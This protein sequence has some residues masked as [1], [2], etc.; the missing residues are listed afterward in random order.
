MSENQ[1][2]IDKSKLSL[3]K[4][5]MNIL[6]PEVDN[7]PPAGLLITDEK[8]LELLYKYNKYLSSFNKFINALRLDPNC[9][10]SG[11]F[12]SLNYENKEMVLKELEQNIPEIFNN[13]L[14]M[15]FLAYYS[16]N[17][18]N[19]FGHNQLH[20]QYYNTAKKT[21]KKLDITENNNYYIL[22]VDTKQFSEIP[23]HY[24]ES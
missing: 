24:L 18:V 2:N 12:E 15:T 23:P 3:L 13:I 11:G 19:S 9:R 17:K 7:L 10:A 20:S 16:N 8:I 6:V 1:K 14:E 5:V 21:K 22:N 4:K